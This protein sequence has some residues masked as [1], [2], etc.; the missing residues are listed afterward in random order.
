MDLDQATKDIGNVTVDVKKIKKLLKWAM[1]HCPEGPEHA[2]VHFAAALAVLLPDEVKLRAITKIVNDAHGEAVQ[3]VSI[4]MGTEADLP[5]EETMSDA[6]DLG[7]A[8]LQTAGMTEKVASDMT[9][10]ELRDVMIPKG[11][12]H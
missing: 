4:G 8:R 7:T 10:D 5:S 2:A 11:Q 3:A 6:I 1:K 9:D 12:P